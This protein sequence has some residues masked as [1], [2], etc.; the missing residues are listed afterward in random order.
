MG[1]EYSASI[2]DTRAALDRAAA[3]VEG[4]D[5]ERGYQVFLKGLGGSSVDWQLRVWCHADEYWNVWERTIQA[6]KRELDAAGIGIPFPQM[7]VHL[8]G[9]LDKAA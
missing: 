9:R 7:D 1:V 3:S 2:D 5:E 8:D 4:R 6:V